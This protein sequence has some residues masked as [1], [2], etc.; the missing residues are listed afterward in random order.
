MIEDHRRL[1]LP[2]LGGG[3]IEIE[4]NFDK[5]DE[6]KNSKVLRL[7]I[8]GKHYDVSAKDLVSFLILVGDLNVKKDLLPIK[9][10]KISTTERMVTATFTASKD[11]KKGDK[12]TYAA[13]YRHSHESAE[14]MVAGAV[15]NAI[16]NKTQ[17]IV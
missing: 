10:T 15:K 14:E 17:I 11:Y 3:E 2:L 8:N 12:I 5:S 7:F 1:C 4:V 9:V 16:K 13:P 6:V